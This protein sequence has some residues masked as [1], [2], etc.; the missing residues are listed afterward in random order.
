MKSFYDPSSSRTTTAL[1][2]AVNS[3]S[4]TVRASETSKGERRVEGVS[5]ISLL[6]GCMKLSNRL[7]YVSYSTKARSDPNLT[8]PAIR[9]FGNR[10]RVLSNC[11][12]TKILSA[13]QR[14]S[15]LG[16]LKNL[17]KGS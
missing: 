14:A 15:P 16:I 5:F 6:A 8:P 9:I 7:H 12:T 11:T 1:R 13:M 10:V 2:L 4:L 17:L 3:Q